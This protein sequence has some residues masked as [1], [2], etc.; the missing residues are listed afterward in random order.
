MA[1]I[2]DVPRID[3]EVHALVDLQFDVEWWEDDRETL[4]VTVT[5]VVGAIVGG[6][7]E[8]LFADFTSF[9]G[10]RA[11]IRVPKEEIQT[12]APFS[13]G[14]WELGLEADD[15]RSEKVGRGTAHYHGVVAI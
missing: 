14:V 12:W 11:M 5:G 15:D 13:K 8:H 9:E 3:L 1:K 2:G 4:P 6:N 10:N 7:E